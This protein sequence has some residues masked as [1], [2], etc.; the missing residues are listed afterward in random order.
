MDRSYYH[1]ALD[2]AI[3]TAVVGPPMLYFG[4]KDNIFQIELQQFSR[5]EAEKHIYNYDDSQK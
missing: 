3:V 5:S 2:T 1:S 4:G